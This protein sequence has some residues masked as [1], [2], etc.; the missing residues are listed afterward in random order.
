MREK[1][2]TSHGGFASNASSNCFPDM[3]WIKWEIRHNLWTHS[4]CIVSPPYFNH[5]LCC[6]TNR[7]LR[8]S[9]A[10]LTRGNAI[11]TIL[12]TNFKITSAYACLSCVVQHGV[13]SA[14]EE[15]WLETRFPSIFSLNQSVY[16]LFCFC[17]WFF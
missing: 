8:L 16:V 7:V 6:I 9:L 10:A 14:F 5:K 4:S 15:F 13:V 11:N 2:K 12:W 17:F 3:Y 1:K